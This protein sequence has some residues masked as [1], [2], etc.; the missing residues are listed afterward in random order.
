MHP[1]TQELLE[2]IDRQRAALQA[3]FDAV[4][5][6]SRNVSPAD[7]RWSPAEIVE[8]VSIVN[9]GIARMLSTR[10]ADAKS[11]GL[12]PEISTEPVL[13][14]ID[15]AMMMDR[16]R[17]FVAPTRVRPAG[18]PADAAWAELERS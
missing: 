13:P 6:A 17:R 7:G 1:R 11:A 10:I 12:G 16:S 14:T 8:H 3:A 4:P 2:Y 18:L 5:V 9:S 15:V